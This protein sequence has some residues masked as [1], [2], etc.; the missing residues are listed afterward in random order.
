MRKE[1]R[2]RQ[3]EQ[4]RSEENPES[5]PQSRTSEQIKGSVSSAQPAKPPR[6][7]KL[8]LPD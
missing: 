7:G 3:Q 6:H 5:K 2:V 4:N 8:P 1:D